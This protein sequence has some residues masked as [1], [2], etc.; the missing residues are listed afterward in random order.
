MPQKEEGDDE[1]EH[2]SLLGGTNPMVSS[3]SPPPSPTHGEDEEDPASKKPAYV[4]KLKEY[5]RKMTENKFYIALFLL[6]TVFTLFADDI[7]ILALPKS[8]D[9]LMT[10]LMFATLLLFGTLSKITKY[11]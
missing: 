6:A 11:P 5:L 7:R 8:A 1:Q 4:D 10:G 9:L 2:D 3:S